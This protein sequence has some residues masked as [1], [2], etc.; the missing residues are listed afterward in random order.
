[1]AHIPSRL[2]LLLTGIVVLGAGAAGCGQAEDVITPTA[3]ESSEGEQEQPQSKQEQEQSAEPLTL[4]L[5]APEICETERARNVGGWE[6]RTNDQS[7]RVHEFVS[8]GWGVSAEMPV[9]W[10]VDGG[11]PPYTLTIDGEPR[12]AR[13]AYHGQFGE[14]SVGCVDSS[15]GTFFEEVSPQVGVMRLYRANPN[16]D[17]GWKTVR[18]VV[19]DA[20]GRT[21]E[22]TIAVYVLLDLASGTT[23]D[24]LRRGE[25]YR[26][27]GFLITA[28]QDYDVE[29]GGLAQ[30]ECAEDDPDPRCG[31]TFHDFLLVGVD[32]W[33]ALYEDGILH[34]RFPDTAPDAPG[35]TTDPVAAAIDSLVDSVG[36]LPQRVSGQE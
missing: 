31:D 23:G 7:A 33:I 3:T 32:A 20:N 8:A 28:P 5:R 1:M 2:A 4:T 9:R 29:V 36:N 22:A 6:L 27:L 11:A 35:R 19:M 26:V 18:G 10:R 16:V 34:R 30:R 24:V 25:T 17:S 12:D 13:G 21:A 15:V 14:A